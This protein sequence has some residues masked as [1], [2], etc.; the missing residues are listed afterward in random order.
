MYYCTN[1]G[2]HALVHARLIY[3]KLS[4]TQLCQDLFRD[5]MEEVVDIRGVHDWYNLMLGCRPSS[6][7]EDIQMQY[8]LQLR[9]RADGTIDVRSKSAVSARVPW[10]PYHQIMPH[11]QVSATVLPG[12][13]QVPALAPSKAWPQF[14]EQIV[15]CLKKFYTR[16]YRH[17]VHIPAVE[18]QEMMEFLQNGPT[19]PS[20][21]AWIDWSRGVSEAD[22]AADA[23]ADDVDHREAA[24]APVSGP[25]EAPRN[26]KVW[27]PFLAPRENPSG[28]KCRCAIVLIFYMRA[29]KRICIHGP[30]CGSTTHLKVT[31]G[32][33]PLN[34]RKRTQETQVDSDP[35]A[36]A[37]AGAGAEDSEDSDDVVLSKKFPGAHKPFPYPVG[38]WVAVQF[39]DEF[40][41]GTITK[42]YPGED[43]CE[44]VFTDGDREDYEADQITY[45]KQLY[46]LKFAAGKE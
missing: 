13:N 36:D 4:S 14:K 28:K 7:D 30:R 6:A 17:P 18:G 46:A 38:T 16:A 12:R 41:P 23:A 1:V 11:P 37:G 21:P 24:R 22:A 8:S 32:D 2:M 45:A 25:P 27:R 19:P 39:G 42:H 10:G 35:E 44:V 31:H 20:A 33:C 9:A 15:P 43:L 34:P 5:K 26:K 3:Y 29:L 40:F